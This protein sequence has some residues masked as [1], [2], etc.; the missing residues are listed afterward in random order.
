MTEKAIQSHT[1]LDEQD[2]KAPDREC[3]C[4]RFHHSER[5]SIPWSVLHKAEITWGWNCPRAK[6]ESLNHCQFTIFTYSRDPQEELGVVLVE[7][8]DWNPGLV[9]VVKSRFFSI[10]CW[11]LLS[12][13][14]SVS[15]PL[16]PS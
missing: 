15:Q 14:F 10:Y 3:G 6:I 5:V 9:S 4:G 8:T 13:L 7:T 11:V 1:H 2:S 16:S 12:K